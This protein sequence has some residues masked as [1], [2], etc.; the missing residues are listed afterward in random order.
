MLASKVRR[1]AGAIARPL[2]KESTFLVCR[3]FA[4][5]SS[6]V[7][8]SFDFCHAIFG[9]SM[10]LAVFWEQIHDIA[11]PY[12]A[13]AAT[14]IIYIDGHKEKVRQKPEAAPSEPQHCM[15]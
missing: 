8:F 13:F 10:I 15:E 11:V 5:H 3:R 14:L 1:A 9:S 2:R 7:S 4:L 6:A 12:A